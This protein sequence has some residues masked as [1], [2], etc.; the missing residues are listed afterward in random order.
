MRFGLFRRTRSES[1]PEAE[2][3]ARVKAWVA[4][5]ARLPADAAIAVNEIVCTDPSCP[6]TETIV[7]VMQPGRKTEARKVS[8]PVEAVTEADLREALAADIPL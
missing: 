2:A 7:L 1:K 3:I 8:K 5:I 4:E 6:G